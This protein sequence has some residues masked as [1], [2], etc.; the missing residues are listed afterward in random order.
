MNNN[1]NLTQQDIE[2]MFTPVEGRLLTEVQ[3]TAILKIQIEFVE[4]A[5]N[6]NTLVP[7]STYFTRAL[8]K[9]QEAKF[10]CTQAVTHV[11]F[12]QSAGLKKETPH[13]DKTQTN[14]KPGNG[15]NQKSTQASA[16]G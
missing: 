2:K 9:L 1:F 14:Q 7:T 8:G 4:V 12:E 6:L 5:M 10:L 13:G 16:Q 15:T 3:K 11:G